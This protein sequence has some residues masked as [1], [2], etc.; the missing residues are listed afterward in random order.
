M[1]GIGLPELVIILVVAL[2]VFGPKKLPELAKALGKGMAEFKK[3]THEIKESLESNEDLQSVRKDLTDSITGHDQ[4]ETPTEGE[5]PAEES[6][7]FEGYDQL[8][9]SYDKLKTEES[10]NVNDKTKDPAAEE[11]DEHVG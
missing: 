8:M 3:A 10:R 9:E 11:K 2:I 4:S 5:K 7:K 1:F 6:A